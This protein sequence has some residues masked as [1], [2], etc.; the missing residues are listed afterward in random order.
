MFNLKSIIAV[1]VL[2]IAGV[3]AANAQL[4]DGSTIKVTVPNS[5]VLR[6]ETF[7]AGDYTIE[8]TPSTADS[9]SLL[10]LRGNGDAIIFDTVAS[11]TNEA[12]ATTQLVFDTV[13]DTNFLSEI[14]VKGAAV[15]TEIPKTKAQKKAMSA[16][17][18][19]RNYLTITNTGF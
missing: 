1:A 3:T 9:P 5:F 4:V 7:E 18:S 17:S 6:D 2:F 8:R 14:L 19:I 15:K 12:S 11:H 16:N 13:G 10:I